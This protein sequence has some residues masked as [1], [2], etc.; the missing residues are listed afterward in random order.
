[1]PELTPSSRIPTEFINRHTLEHPHHSDDEAAG[2]CT[3]CAADDSS[4]IS[5]GTRS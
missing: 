5:S 3:E 2:K 4:Q 1:M